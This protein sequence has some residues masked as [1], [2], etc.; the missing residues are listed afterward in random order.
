MINPVVF[1]I[2]NGT[3]SRDLAP[4]SSPLTVR[5]PTEVPM[6]VYRRKTVI[7]CCKHCGEEFVAPYHPDDS[8]RAHRGR[9]CSARCSNAFRIPAWPARFWAKVDKNGPI[10]EHRPDLGPCWIWNGATA[11]GYGTSTDS[12]GI[13]NRQAHRISYS[14]AHGDIPDGLQIDHLCRV[15]RC[16]NP[17]HLEPVTHKV[18]TNRGMSP[19]IVAHRSGVCLRGHEMTGDNRVVERDGFLRCRTCRR[20][21]RRK[22]YQALKDQGK[23]TCPGTADATGRDR[24]A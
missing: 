13:K 23:D 24:A 12:D 3:T 9:F 15:R 20:E 22:R 21:T 14:M 8:K 17:A 1:G 7:R 5:L 10:P 6:S 4:N 16:V 19:T 2:M 18:N 11:S